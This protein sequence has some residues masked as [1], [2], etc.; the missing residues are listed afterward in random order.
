M[1]VLPGETGIEASPELAGVPVGLPAGVPNRDW[2]QPGGEA[3]KSLGHLALAGSPA[4]AWSVSIGEGSDSGSYFGGTP[5]VEG[6]RLYTID[7]ASTVR[8][9]DT[10]TGRELWAAPLT[11]PDEGERGASGGGVAVFGGRVYATSGYGLAAA[12]DGTTGQEIWRADLQIPLRGGPTVAEGRVLVMTQDNQLIALDAA[13]GSREWEV[14]GTVEPAGL[15]GAA[16]PAVAQDTAVVG[17]SSGELQAV[18]IENGRLVWQDVL[19]PAG[20]T[21]SLSGLSDIDAPP[22]IDEQGR[23]FAIGHGGRIAAVQLSTGQRVWEQPFGGVSLPWV[24]GDWLF[25]V[26]NKA[27]LVAVAKD[28]GRIRWVSQL[29]RW[30]DPEDRKG[31]I[32]YRGPVLAGD[33]LWLTNSEGEL[34][35]VSPLDGAVQT[36]QEVADGFYLPPIVAGETLYTLDES[37][38]LSAWR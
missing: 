9:F 2:T 28:D 23:V 13:D 4:R 37:G 3:A 21:T 24:A 33:R 6:D 10:A 26:S 38:R 31:A 29:P 1:A 22:A 27:E 18:R 30:R 14:I 25:A 5:V 12:Y 32:R 17:F 36:R 8:G 7:T 16:A 34:L 15:F 11:R 19:A 20:R 35:S